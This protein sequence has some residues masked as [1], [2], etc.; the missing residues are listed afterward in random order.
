MKINGQ[1]LNNKYD[2]KL[3]EVDYNNKVNTN[4]KVKSNSNNEIINDKLTNNLLTKQE[5]NYFKKLFP[6]SGEIIDK[7]ILFNRNAKIQNIETAKGIF[8]DGK[9]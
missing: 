5:R 2:N 1:I 4:N 3:K 7:H 8:V 6:E 9:I